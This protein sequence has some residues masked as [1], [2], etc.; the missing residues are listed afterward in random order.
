MWGRLVDMEQR[1][2]GN[3]GLD[4][5]AIGFG[6]WEMGNRDSGPRADALAG[7]RNTD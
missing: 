1:K 6:C 2:L 4:V 3:T 7:S 5:S